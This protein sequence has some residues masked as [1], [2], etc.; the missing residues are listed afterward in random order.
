M[1]FGNDKFI[2]ATVARVHRD[3]ARIP[4]R[5]VRKP[6]LGAMLPQRE[7]MMPRFEEADHHFNTWFPLREA[8]EP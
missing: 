1:S 7:G 6:Q 4:L 5:D 3:E 8:T 2:L